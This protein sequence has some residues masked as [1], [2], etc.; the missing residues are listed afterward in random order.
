MPRNRLRI[1][2][3]LLFFSVLLMA[4]Q[5]RYSV[6]R[7]F[8]FLAYPLNLVNEAYVFAVTGVGDT[9]EKYAM[10]EERLIELRR[11]LRSARLQ[12]Q[13]FKE[14]Q[15]ENERLRGILELRDEV[16]GYVTTARVVSLGPG[17]WANAYVIDKGSDDNVEKDMVAITEKGLLGKVQEV[18]GSYSVVLLIDDS[19]FSA[20]VRLQDSRA[21]AV[22]SGAGFNR[23]AIKYVEADTKVASG[24]TAVTSGLDGLFPP[25]IP[26]ATVT[27]VST[28]EG[29]LFH[30][31]KA[32]PLVDTGKVEEVIIIKR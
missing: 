27:K 16:G 30:R 20:A 29:A 11:E 9:F 10:S 17:R 25:G 2:L 22:L 15:L 19:R 28:P 31:I 23:C 14:L 8:G 13:R 4:L 24:E 6:V 12:Q 1:F 21:R 32:A 3:T 18:A 5:N 26:A 7:P